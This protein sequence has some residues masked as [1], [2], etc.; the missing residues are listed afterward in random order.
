MLHMAHYLCI[1]YGEKHIGIA[2][3]TSFVAKEIETIPTNQ[4]MIRIKELCIEY[5]IT[6][7][8][9]GISENQMAQKTQGFAQSLVDEFHLPIHFQDETL[10][11][12]ETRIRLAQKGAKRKIR[13]S[14]IDHYVAAAILQEYLDS[15]P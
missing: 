3:A 8:V 11:S 4:A 12:Q 13:E 5:Q 14:K 2:V 9:I 1:D 7:F 6:D 10:S 15:N